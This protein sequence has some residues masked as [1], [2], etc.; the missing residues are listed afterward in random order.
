[1]SFGDLPHILPK[2]DFHRPQNFTEIDSNMT[3]YIIA[4]TSLFEF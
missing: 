2:Y 4:M 3:P 1:M